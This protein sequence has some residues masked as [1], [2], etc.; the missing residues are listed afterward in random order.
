MRSMPIVPLALLLVAL[1]S[2][3]ARG[4]TRATTA[5][6]AGVVLDESNAV[7]P[8]ATVSATNTATGHVRSTVTEADGRFA[9][10]A[11][12]VGTYTI[13]AELPGFSE[14]LLENVVLE[15]GTSVQLTIVL[16]VAATQERVTVVGDVPL[17]DVQKTEVSTVVSRQQIESLPINGRNFISFSVI[18]PGVSTDRTPQQ[19][20]AATSGLTFAG[21]RAR[22]NNITVDGVDNNDATAGSV[23]ATFSQ[24]A[25]REFQVLTNSYSAEFGK[26]SGGVVNIV[27]KSGTNRTDGTAFFYYRDQ[28]LNARGHFEDF[29]PAGS[30][31]DAPKA[32]FNQKQFG[33][34]VGGPIRRDRA[35]YFLSFERLDVAT[36]NFV[37][38]DDTRPVSHPFLPV[39]IGTTASLLRAAGFPIETG[40]VAYNVESTQFLAKV[41]Q[42]VTPT[43]YLSLRFNAADDLNENIEPFGGIVAKSRAGALDSR[44]YMFAAS[45]TAVM[46]DRMVN[47]LR[48]QVANRDQLVRSL[49]PTCSGPCDREDEGGPTVEILGVASVGRQRFTPQPRVNTRYQVLDTL[50][51]YAGSHQIKT[52][53]D[54]S[55]IDNKDQS[56]PLHFGGRYVFAPFPAATAALFGLPRATSAFENFILGLPGAYVQGY[57]SSAAPYK[58][59]DLSLFLQD[60]WRLS[61]RLTLK[62]GVRYQKQFWPDVQFRVFGYPDSYTFPEDSNNIAPR[63]AF[64]W[65][66]AGDRRTSIHGAYGLFYDN[67]ITGIVGIGDVID[68]E[69]GVRTLVA[70]GAL[71]IGAWRAPGRRLP[72]AAVGRFASTEISIDPA[73]ETPYAHHV[74]AGVDRE[75]PGQMSL[76]AN[77]VYVRGSDQIGTI[78]YNPVVPALGPGRRPHDVNGVPGTSASV[79]QYTSFGET[80]YT[81]LTVALSRRFS[82]RSQFLASYTL[83]K[84]EDTSTDFQTA[85]LP[86][87][88][89]VGR[90]PADLNGLPVGFDPDSERGPSVQDQRH[91]F[92]LSG[93]YVAPWEVQLSTIVTIGSGRPY[94]ILAGF[95]FNGDGDGGTIPGPDRARTNPPD[96]SSAVGRN[97]EN[98]PVQ[99]TVDLRVAKRFGIGDVARF[100]AIFEVFNLLNRTNFTEVNNIAGPGAFPGGALSSF[101]Q[102]TQAAAPLQVQLAARISF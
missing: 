83:S 40:N 99:A 53:F 58:Y 2:A 13:R 86:A 7:L 88:N 49:D 63:L 66:P 74:S 77:F 81:G 85:F 62:A 68:G 41:D 90:D 79:L 28:S 57:G 33:A 12:P 20:A 67:H 101:G 100:D 97:T 45:H 39:V 3:P 64:S 69:D 17:V 5:D 50:S 46:S 4:Q 14:Q 56:L 52:G 11:L 47:E 55:Y 75:L 59:R 37:T 87:S 42:Y 73:L 6:L 89:G 91:R 82:G 95:D 35:F 19:G 54:F 70:R 84:A 72:E 8:G 60:D 9:L 61:P 38:I 51:F 34:T 29:D 32:P 98:L 44:D 71:A 31:I 93:L 24:E 30:R 23:R 36:S 21:Q 92:V 25:V 102:F 96:P 43:Q 27:T 76:S 10:P 94:N 18:T 78:D 1:T 15:L 48:F 22:S 65:D 26:A 16:R 80:R